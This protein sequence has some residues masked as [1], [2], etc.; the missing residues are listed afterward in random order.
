[1][2]LT[3]LVGD[4][5]PACGTAGS[6]QP[7]PEHQQPQ[8]GRPSHPLPGCSREGD[9]AAPLLTIFLW[10]SWSGPHRQSGTIQSDTARWR[11]ERSECAT[12]QMRRRP[13]QPLPTQ[14]P[15]RRGCR[16]RL[17]V[18]SAHHSH[19]DCHS[20][21]S[22]RRTPG[23]RGSRWAHWGPRACPARRRDAQTGWCQ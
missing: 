20:R 15:T 12:C 8:W 18:S 17:P 6:P 2:A 10:A 23:G 19:P 7:H 3:N 22:P 21:S 11:E 14:G 13:P 16:A 9:R 1:M 4:Q 5:G